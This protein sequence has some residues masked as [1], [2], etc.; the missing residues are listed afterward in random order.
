M[1][2]ERVPVEIE[3]PELGKTTDIE[4]DEIIDLVDGVVEE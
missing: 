3:D 1:T 2:E 4:A